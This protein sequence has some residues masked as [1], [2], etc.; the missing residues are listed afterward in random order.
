MLVNDS[1]FQQSQNVVDTKT[2]TYENVLFSDDITNFVGM[3]TREVS[4]IRN[5]VQQTVELT[6]ELEY[7]DL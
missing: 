2:A 3:F 1:L 5:V 7:M 6:G 4:N